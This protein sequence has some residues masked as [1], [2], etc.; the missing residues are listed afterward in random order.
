MNEKNEILSSVNN[1][2]PSGLKKKKEGRKE[3]R[4]EERGTMG[5]QMEGRPQVFMII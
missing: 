1:L 5:R 4:K 2:T 3:K